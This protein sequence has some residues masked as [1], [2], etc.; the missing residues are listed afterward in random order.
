[1][2]GQWFPRVAVV[3][4]TVTIVAGFL[5]VGPQLGLALGALGVGALL[6]WAARAG[7]KGAIETV[8]V[9]RLRRRVLVVVTVELDDRAVEAIQSAGEYDRPGNQA[10]MLVVAP[11][12]PGKLGRWATDVM[13]ARAEAQRKLVVSVAALTKAGITARASVGDDDP[14]L[15]VEDA[16]R[17]FAA[18]EVI[19]VT[20]PGAEDEPGERAASELQS[21][22]RQPLER[23][24][25]G[26]DR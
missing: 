3:V 17:E 7:E 15:A 14:V 18:S 22:L 21:R 26:P 9:T 13:K 8:P 11:A 2:T 1:M 12:S 10:E 25:V 16:L 20:G 19:L 24:I 6:V 23:V 5:T 4:L